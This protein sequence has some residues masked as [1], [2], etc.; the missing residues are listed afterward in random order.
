MHYRHSFS[1]VVN[2]LDLVFTKGE[3][4]VNLLQYLE[5]MG[6]SHHVTLHW[7]V[8]CYQYKKYSKTVK[9]NYSSEGDYTEM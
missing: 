6:K 2:V 1:Q 9:Y 4:L 3:E 7:T 5:P 8:T